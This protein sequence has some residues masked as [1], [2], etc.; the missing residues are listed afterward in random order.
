MKKLLN[1]ILAMAFLSSASVSCS[2]DDSVPTKEID[3]RLVGEW[4]MLGA[5]T[6]GEDVSKGMDVYLIIRNDGSFELY[7]KNSLTQ[8]ERY[9]L[10]TGEC[11]VTDSI[12]T[13]EYADGTPWGGKWEYAMTINGFILKS[14]NLLEEQ[15]YIKATVPA[16]IRE[17]ANP[18]T[19]SAGICTPIL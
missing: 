9:D 12:L 17:D 15:R 11:W 14:Y 16:E 13:G 1:I 5:R 6:E 4:H 7:Q 10:Y 18:V 19:K 2:K 3:A 8:S